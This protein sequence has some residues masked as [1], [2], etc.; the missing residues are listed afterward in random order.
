[1]KKSRFTIPEQIKF[2]ISFTNGCNPYVGLQDYVT[3]DACGIERG[4]LE[5]VK[6]SDGTKEMK[7]T[8]NATSTRW[9]VKHLGKTVT[10]SELF[11]S[12]VFTQ[13]VLE[14]LDNNVIKDK[15]NLPEL[16]DYTDLANSIEN[17][18]EEDENE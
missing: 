17:L 10:T 12:K 1:L 15:F 11:S 5:E 7:F 6:N 18:S 4:K 2:H 14:Q 8:A 3:W 9:A 13:E 16:S